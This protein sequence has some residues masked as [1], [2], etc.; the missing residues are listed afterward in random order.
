MTNPAATDPLS[1]EFWDVQPT[2]LQVARM[3]EA[4]R[5]ANDRR[6]REDKNKRDAAAKI[7][8][9]CLAKLID[10][11]VAEKN[12]RSL[13]GKWRNQLKDDDRL[14]KLVHHA[15]SISTP[16]PVSYMT[17]AVN[18]S[19]KRARNVKAIQKGT[20]EELG[21]EAPRQGPDGPRFFKTVRGKAWRDPFGKIAILPAK[22][23]EQIPTL[24]EDPGVSE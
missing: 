9:D 6:A 2:A 4:L 3:N 5:L 22:E 23:G 16:D 14:S 20:W 24:D 1:D 19:K 7:F 11:G 15:H 13:L 10:L 12:A 8:G 21:W 18:G 17:K